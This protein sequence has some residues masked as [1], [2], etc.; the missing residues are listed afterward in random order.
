MPSVFAGEILGKIIDR[1]Q[2][3]ENEA[4]MPEPISGGEIV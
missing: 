1:R 3:I 4:Q 2:Q